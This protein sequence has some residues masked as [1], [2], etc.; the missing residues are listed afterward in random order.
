MPTLATASVAIVALIHVAISVAE[1]FFWENPVIYERLG[2]TAEI[3]HQVA[4]IVQNAGLYNS[5]IAA[6]LLWSLFTQD[7]PLQI[8]TFFLVCVLVAGIFGAMTLSSNT[9]V[10]QALPAILALILVW[11]TRQRL[12]LKPE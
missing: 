10:L 9:L 2:F 3:A 7:R 5:F 6:G 1:I 4:A 8:R 11:V 12:S